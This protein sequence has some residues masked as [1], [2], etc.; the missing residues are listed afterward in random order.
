MGSFNCAGSKPSGDVT[1]WL[2]GRADLWIEQEE[3]DITPDILL[4]GLQE[5]CD[6]KATNILG[7]E[8]SAHRWVDFLLENVI[9][10][11]GDDYKMVA[12]NNLVGLVTVIF[13][14]TDLVPSQS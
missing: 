12:T 7:D 1:L 2:R 5:M 11:Y 3:K 13:A 6:L 14:R 9:R 10:A 8:K 4:I